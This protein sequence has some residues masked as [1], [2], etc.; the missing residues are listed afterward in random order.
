MLGNQTGARVEA[1]QVK[2]LDVGERTAGQRLD[3]LLLRELKGCP[4]SMIYRIIR[5]GEVRI[6]GKRSKPE[7]RLQLGDKVRIPP[8]RLPDKAQQANPGKHLAALLEASILSENEEFLVL[9]KP[10]GLAV[11]GGSG[12]RLG[13]IEALRQL[14]TEWQDLELV[15]R[16]D[17]DTSGC[18]VLSKNTIF[19]REINK[20]LKNNSAIKIYSTLVQGYWP[21]TLQLIDAPLAKNQLESGER[22]VKVSAEGKK[23]LTRFRVVERFGR[24]AT[25]LEVRLET[26]RTHQI[27]VHCQFAGHPIV[28]DTKYGNRELAAAL[29]GI[30]KLCLHASRLEFNYPPGGPRHEFFAAL[31]QDFEEALKLLRSKTK[32]VN[33]GS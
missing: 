27:R 4:K 5:K 9:N 26:G 22:M 25:L 6:N 19:L 11:H 31:N 29:Q 20:I 18:L 33:N 10:A 16:L 28:G 1:G 12:V 24:Q 8:L 3:N 13:L 2:Y 17:R 21:D 15:H 23:S 7:T 30:K 32:S 14:R